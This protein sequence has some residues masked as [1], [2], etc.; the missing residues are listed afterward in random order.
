M[1]SRPSEPTESGEDAVPGSYVEAAE[2]LLSLELFGMDFGIGRM[3]RLLAKLGDPQAAFPAIHVVGSNGKSSTT[4][5]AEA[6]LRAHGKSTGAYLSPHVRTWTERVL[7]DGQPVGEEEFALAAASVARAARAVDKEGTWGPVT[8]FEAVTAVGFV[9]LAR[10]AVEVA[11]VE[12]GLGGRLD[13]TNVI[14]AP[15]SVLASVGLEHTRWLGDTV[16]AIA[17][18]KLD[19]VAA[20]STLVIPADLNPEALPVAAA[21]AEQVG[22]RIV[23]AP[24]SSQLSPEG[25]PPYLSHN[26]ALAAAAAHA[27]LG[28]LDE[29]AVREAVEA[30]ALRMRGRFEP[31]G[32]APRTILDGAHNADGVKALLRALGEAG[33]SHPV[34]ACVS[35]LD[36]KDA[37]TMI[38]ALGEVVDRFVF[39]RSAHPR[40]VDPAR[41]V[42]VAAKMAGES[43][44]EI[45]EEPHAALA[46]ARRE[47]GPAG[48]VVVTGSLYL[49]ADLGRPPG[50]GGGSTL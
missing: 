32:E 27:F 17:S 20:G 19:V 12:A 50:A 13:A 44:S 28:L 2:W 47:A 35:I 33:A 11:V 37:A 31:I 7:V 41:L 1:N 46:A 15:V 49:I 14:A 30:G 39:T 21:R 38:A 45:V 3:T 36:D 6:I 25:T 4:R 24:A 34:V 22:A 29:G 26:L 48:T 10:A 43:P 23:V 5:L 42:E 8:Q 40:S 9:L 16:A 18:E